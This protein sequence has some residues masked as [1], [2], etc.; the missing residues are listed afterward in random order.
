M[1]PYIAKGL[2]R[3]PNINT[4]LSSSALRKLK[5]DANERDFLNKSQLR[6]INAGDDIRL[7]AKYTTHADPA[8]PVII[9][10]HG[11]LGCSE[12]R[13]L[14]SLSSFL[15]EQGY[16]IV[17]LNFRDHGFSEY[18]NE[19]LFHSCRIQEAIDACIHI[20]NE[21]TDSTLSIIGFS[22]GGNFALRI[23][24]L[25]NPEQLRLHKTISFCPVMDPSSTLN[26]LE[27]AYPAYSHYFIRLWKGS[28]K[29]KI[30]AFPKIYSKN[31]LKEF[32]SLRIATERL[33]IEYAGFDSLDSY[34]HGYAITGEKLSTLQA[35]ANIV[36]AQDDPIIPWENHQQL[37]ISPSLSIIHCQHGGHCGFLAP[38]LRSPWLNQFSLSA[39]QN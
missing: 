29:R 11:W 33:A 17:R 18:L 19:G 6:I 14:I 10:L 1:E 30:T 24:A 28:F 4:I 22:L 27:H 37:A 7:T 39:L 2:L 3:N 32:K 8:A 21:F 9:L 5:L 25:T 15:F 23:N 26:A 20:Q 36:L 13:Y 31:L 34:L 12:S 35:P 38:N 16:N